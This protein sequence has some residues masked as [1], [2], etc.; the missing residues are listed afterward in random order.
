[1]MPSFILRGVI[2]ISLLILTSGCRSFPGMSAEGF[3]NPQDVQ[4]T[5]PPPPVAPRMTYLGE[6][7]NPQQLGARVSFWNRSVNLLT[8]SRYG[9]EGWTR[10]TGLGLDEAGNLCIA[11]PGTASVGWFDHARKRFTRWT[12]IGR[13]PFSVPVAIAKRGERIYV[14]DTG[15][16]KVLVF[17]T[18]GRKK[19]EIGFPLERPSGLVLAGDQL[20]VS[21]AKV[22][23][24]FFFT[25]DGELIRQVGTRGNGEAAFNFP[26]HLA[27]GPDR[28]YVADAM[29]FRIQVL[30]AS[31][32]PLARF[33]QMGQGSGQFSRPKGVATD[34]E[35]RVYVVDALFD[36]VQIFDRDEQFLMH[37]GEPG[38]APGQFWLPGGIAIDPHGVV[39]VADAYNQRIQMFRILEESP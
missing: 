8:G 23:A 7:R 12:Q 32:R 10:P 27:A 22:H 2:L 34:G 15:L 35:G 21:D 4:R 28:L 5:W 37:W 1:M 14:A 30:D 19:F 11:D 9:R 29:N 6:A 33:G 26:T 3:Y 13:E 36:N 31:G 20:I 16:A 18:R 38:S 24:L 39:Y 17:D 25:L